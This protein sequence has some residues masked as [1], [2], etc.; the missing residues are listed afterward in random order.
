MR[1]KFQETTFGVAYSTTVTTVN[2][3]KVPVCIAF[4]FGNNPRIVGPFGITQILA[5][6]RFGRWIT[7]KDRRA[8]VRKYAE[9]L[10]KA[11]I[12]VNQESVEPPPGYGQSGHWN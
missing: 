5:P 2:G 4:P 9:Q 8:Y 1:I 10:Q 7:N 6:E 11:T 3:H 12:F